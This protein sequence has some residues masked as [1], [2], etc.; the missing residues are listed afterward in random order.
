MG[1]D[2]TKNVVATAAWRNEAIGTCCSREN[3][4]KCRGISLNTEYLCNLWKWQSDL[5]KGAEGRHSDAIWLHTREW[6]WKMRTKEKPSPGS[7]TRCY[8]VVMALHVS[9]TYPS[10]CTQPPS[11][12]KAP[13]ILPLPFLLQHLNTLQWLSCLQLPQTLMS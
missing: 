9:H 4:K 13:P 1:S 11:S 8:W 6:E 2:G 5:L 3:F 7:C 12:L 10:H